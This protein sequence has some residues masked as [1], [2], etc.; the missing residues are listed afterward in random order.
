MDEQCRL[1]SIPVGKSTDFCL[2]I[3]GRDSSAM[4]LNLNSDVAALAER[5]QQEGED[6]Q[7]VVKITAG[8]DRALP[9]CPDFRLVAATSRTSTL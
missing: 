6:V 5:R 3:G 9:S 8:T 4:G 1:V 2:P 7:T